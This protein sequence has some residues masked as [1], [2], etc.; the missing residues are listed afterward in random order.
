[1]CNNLS[2]E[3]RLPYTSGSAPT[4]KDGILISTTCIDSTLSTTSTTTTTT[5]TEL[6]TSNF[7]HQVE[8]TAQVLVSTTPTICEHLTLGLYL[9]VLEWIAGTLFLRN[10]KTGYLLD[11]ACTSA[12]K[13]VFFLILFFSG[14][15][16][17]WQTTETKED[18]YLLFAAKNSLKQLY[19][20]IN[21]DI[22]CKKV[23][24]F[25]L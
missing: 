21:S 1:M 9:L 18:E 3:K 15:A 19:S 4:S 25:L 12:Q 2:W 11:T 16:M 8:K 13:W 20:A 5:S 17:P 14:S 7:F 22:L 24:F 6:R 23:L 10:R